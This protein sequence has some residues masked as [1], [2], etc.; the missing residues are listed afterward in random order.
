MARMEKQSCVTKLKRNSK[1]LKSRIPEYGGGGVV[2]WLKNQVIHDLTF[3]PSLFCI[4]IQ[5]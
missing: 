2:P 4:W 1:S 3:F 5:I